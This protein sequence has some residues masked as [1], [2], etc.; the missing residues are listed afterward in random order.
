MQGLSGCFSILV[1]A[2]RIGYSRFERDIGNIREQ[3]FHDRLVAVVGCVSQRTLPLCV[4][5]SRVCSM[6]E[7]C[8]NCIVR[9]K[10]GR[11]YERRLPI[12]GSVWVDTAF[13]QE[14]DRGSIFAGN[15]EMEKFYVFV[16]VL[17][18]GIYSL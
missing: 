8:Y 13:Q 10:G 2:F 15:G 11:S 14:N 17:N 5:S 7:E 1:C 9:S 4:S 3:N 18:C 6:S 16:L 12:P